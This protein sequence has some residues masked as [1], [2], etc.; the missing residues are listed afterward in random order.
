MAC[1]LRK[2]HFRYF[3]EVIVL[4]IFYIKNNYMC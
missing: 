1:G 4:C 3:R 2:S